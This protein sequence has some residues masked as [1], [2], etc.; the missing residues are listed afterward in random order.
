MKKLKPK[1]ILNKLYV[2]LVVIALSALIIESCK[3]DNHAEQQTTIT[4]PAVIQAKSWYESTFP[5][6]SNK[7]NTQ[8]TTTNSDLSQL[9]KPDWQHNASYTRFN[10]PVIEIP[11]DPSSKF[12]P[13]IKNKTTGWSSNQ[14]YSRSSFILLNNGSGYDAYVMTLI[15]DSAYLKNDLSKLDRNKYN[16]RDANYSGLVLY[17]TPK[18]KYV[19]GWR[20]KDGHI[21]S[22]GSQSGSGIKVQSTGNSKLKPMYVEC[23]D[24]WL[25]SPSGDVMIYLFTSCSGGDGGTGSN[26]DGGP[27]S[28]SGGEGSGGG[29]GGSGSG[30]ASSPTPPPP[31][32]GAPPIIHSG[33]N[34]V[35]NNVPPDPYPGD[36]FPP[37]PTDPCTVEVPVPHMDIID[38]LSSKYPCAKALVAALP[39]LNT[40]IAQ[41]IYQAFDSKDGNNMIFLEGDAAY[42]AANKQEDGHTVFDNDNGFLTNKIYINPAVLANSSNEYRLVTLYHEAIHAFLN[43]EHTTLTSAA[44]AAKY[45]MVNVVERPNFSQV[46][47]ADKYDYYLDPAYETKVVGKDHLTMAEY[48]IT[49]LK[50]AILAYNPNFPPERALALAKAGIVQDNSTIFANY[51]DQERDVTK[52]ASVG[53][54]CP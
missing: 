2:L 47:I 38:S 51:N 35:V 11:I 44:F 18:G 13:S 21:V 49:G 48:F 50:D 16:K 5:V 7:Q 32:N 30:S 52:G 14:A 43:S 4:D 27:G 17:F 3:K 1:P 26:G 54:K 23:W 40:N 28:S 9:I 53:T 8:A 36:G 37:P 6:N 42:F 46:V 22:S 41:L 19:G 39:N 33:G 24:Y 20:Y 34:L 31:C 25:S 12:N 10:K 45:P 29:T 15:A